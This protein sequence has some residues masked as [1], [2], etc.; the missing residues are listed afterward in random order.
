M[1]IAAI[2]VGDTSPLMIWRISDSIS[3]WKISRC[4]M[5]RWQRFLHA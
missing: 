1:M 2:S 5:M 3:S 4:S